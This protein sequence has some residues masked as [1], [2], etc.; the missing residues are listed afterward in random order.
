MFRP[1]G[2]GVLFTVILTLVQC[3]T[4][5]LPK[6]LLTATIRL[7]PRFSN[8]LVINPIVLFPPVRGRAVLIKHLIDW[9]RQRLLAGQCRF[10]RVKTLASRFAPLSRVSSPAAT[11]VLPAATRPTKLFVVMGLILECLVQVPALLTTVCIR[12]RLL[13]QRRTD[14][15]FRVL[16]GVRQAR[17]LR[18]SDCGR[19]ARWR[20]A[21]ASGYPTNV[22][23]QVTS[24][25]ADFI[26]RR[27]CSVVRHTC[28]AV[29]VIL[30][31]RRR[32][33]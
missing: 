3:S 16:T 20:R 9:A 22:F 5:R 2:P 11:T 10:R 23:R 14:R 19:G 1:I 29:T 27:N 8:L 26:A 21:R 15:L 13:T 7:V 18:V 24:G 6:P 25:R 33:C 31:F 4:L 30:T 17:T 12:S 32:I 28:F